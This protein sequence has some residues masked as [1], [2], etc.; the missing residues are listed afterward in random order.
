MRSPRTSSPST[1]RYST[2]MAPM[3]PSG[4]STKSWASSGT[5]VASS[6]EPSMATRTRAESSAG[7]PDTLAALYTTLSPSR[8]TR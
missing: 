4:R 7:S 6:H 3:P 1:S 2:V 5:G 8:R